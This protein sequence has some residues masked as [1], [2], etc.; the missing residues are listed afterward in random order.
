LTKTADVSTNV[1]TLKAHICA[2]A[3]TATNFCQT[4]IRASKFKDAPDIK[5]FVNSSALKTQAALMDTNAFADV[6]SC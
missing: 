2:L 4:D 6:V 1:P 5:D 3:A